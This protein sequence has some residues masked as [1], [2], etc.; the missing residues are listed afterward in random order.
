MEKFCFPSLLVH[1]FSFA[2]KLAATAF[3]QDAIP[4]SGRHPYFR[5]TNPGVVPAQKERPIGWNF[6][7]SLTSHVFDARRHSPRCGRVAGTAAIF[8]KQ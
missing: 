2:G 3:V 8:V 5:K 1:R 6:L 7:P 4:S